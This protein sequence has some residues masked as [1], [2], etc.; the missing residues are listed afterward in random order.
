MVQKEFIGLMENNLLT[1]GWLSLRLNRT[2]GITGHTNQCLRTVMH[3]Y[4]GGQALLK[5]L[6]KHS[7]ILPSNLCITL[8]HMEQ[9]GLVLR[10]VDDVDRR[11]TWYSLTAKG[12]KL[13]KETMEDMRNKIATIF[14]DLAKSDEAK[15]TSALRTVNE[16]LLRLKTNYEEKI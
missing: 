8:R 2:P 7:D 13:A 4:I 11:N 16:V 9:D 3:L 15:L 5:D 12:T 14:T 1:M 10:K 6:A